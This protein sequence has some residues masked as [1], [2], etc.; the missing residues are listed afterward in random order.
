MPSPL[1]EQDQGSEEGKDASDLSTRLGVSWVPD[2]SAWAGWVK[3]R[4]NGGLL[5]ASNG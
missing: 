5:S 2:F 4:P 3:A 1:D